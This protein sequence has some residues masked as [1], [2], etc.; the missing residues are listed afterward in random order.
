MGDYQVR[1]CERLGVKFPLPTR[2]K[3]VRHNKISSL[4][5]VKL[6]N[7]TESFLLHP[8]TSHILTIVFIGEFH[9]NNFILFNK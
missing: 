9:N 1:F 4:V 2:Q 5:R 7:I 8:P 6:S 3:L